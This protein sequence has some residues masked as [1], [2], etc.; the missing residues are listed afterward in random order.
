MGRYEEDM[1]VL[2][3]NWKQ[4]Y[5]REDIKS[6]LTKITRVN[7]Y[8]IYNTER[9]VLLRSIPSGK[10]NGSCFWDLKNVET[11]QKV[12][13]I[14]ELAQFSWRTCQSFN[15]Q[16]LSSISEEEPYNHVIFTKKAL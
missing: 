7:Y 15:M 16:R 1:D 11:N 6:M 9:G 10:S 12:L 2:L 13:L 14:N 5:S 3:K 8:Q 4:L